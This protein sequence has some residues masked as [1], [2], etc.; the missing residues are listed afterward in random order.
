MKTIIDKIKSTINNEN[1]KDIN[2]FYEL[3]NL[4]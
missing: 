1:Q 4:Y 3:K 2:D